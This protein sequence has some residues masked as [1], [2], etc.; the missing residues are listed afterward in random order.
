MEDLNLLGV[1]EHMVL[2]GGCGKQSSLSNFIVDGKIWTL[3]ENDDDDDGDDDDDD[4]EDDGDEEE[5]DD[6]DDNKLI[7]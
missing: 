4:G 2:N 7:K 5:N 1:E 6:D 3:N